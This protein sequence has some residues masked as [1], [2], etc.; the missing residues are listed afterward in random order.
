MFIVTSRGDRVRPVLPRGVRTPL[1]MAGAIGAAVA[2]TLGLMSAGRPIGSGLDD[3]V[4]AALGLHAFSS[5][6]CALVL[7]L[8]VACLGSGRR[9][10]PA[11]TVAGPA[12]ADV[13]V[14]TR[15]HA[16]RC[17][18]HGNLAYSLGGTSQAP[19]DSASSSA[20]RSR[21]Q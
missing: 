1:G 4:A 18:I 13:V 2:V 11:L 10:L 19:E 17:M 3:R 15:K 14:I 9:R 16:I 5:V 6:P 21:L 7:V 8:V 20:Q 12:A